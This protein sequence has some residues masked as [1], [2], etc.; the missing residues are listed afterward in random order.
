MISKYIPSGEDDD[1]DDVC[2]RKNFLSF[3]GIFPSSTIVC[4]V[5]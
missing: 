5:V 2:R 3:H 4:G 1:D